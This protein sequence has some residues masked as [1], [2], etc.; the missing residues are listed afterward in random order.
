MNYSSQNPFAS[1]ATAAEASHPRDGMTIVCLVPLWVWSPLSNAAAYLGTPADPLSTFMAMGINLLWLWMGA[2]VGARGNWLIRF[3]AVVGIGLPLG[4]LTYL[5]G[6]YYGPGLV[7]AYILGNLALGAIGW[8]MIPNGRF[9][10]VGAFSVGYF[11]GSFLCLVGSVPLAGAG[12]I[13]GYLAVKK[14]LPNVEP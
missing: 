4:Y 13:I 8:R 1:P 2:V 7:A 9:P 3:L 14:T 6:V 5:L 12:S 10:I 11:L